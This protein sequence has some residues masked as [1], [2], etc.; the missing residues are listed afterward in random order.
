MAGIR[1]LSATRQRE[2]NSG[3]AKLLENAKAIRIN[4]TIFA[5]GKDTAGLQNNN[6][7]KYILYAS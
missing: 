4:L 6:L 1:I 3:V 5:D 2:N 7:Q